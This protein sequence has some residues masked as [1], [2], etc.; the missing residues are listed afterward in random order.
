MSK[1]GIHTTTIYLMI[2][3]KNIKS[4]RQLVTSKV[5]TELFINYRKT[6]TFE[7]LFLFKIKIRR[8]LKLDNLLLKYNIYFGKQNK[9]MLN[10]PAYNEIAKRR[11]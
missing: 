5:Q 7:V 4:L 9:I 2:M 10:N 6:G 3:L 1:Y 8:R 11:K